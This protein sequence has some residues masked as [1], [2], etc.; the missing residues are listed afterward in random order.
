MNEQSPYQQPG[1]RL[2]KWLLIII[3]GTLAIFS[4]N[5]SWLRG[6]VWTLVVFGICV[7]PF[8]R[9]WDQKWFWRANAILVILHGTILWLGMHFMNSLPYMALFIPAVGELIVFILILW[10]F[11]PLRGDR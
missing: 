5:H 1:F 11:D 8:R 6:I 3:G 7:Y 9:A 10:R 4:D 2:F